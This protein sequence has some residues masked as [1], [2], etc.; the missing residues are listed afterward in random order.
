MEIVDVSP[1]RA[2][3]DITIDRYLQSVSGKALCVAMSSSGR[4]LYLGGHSGVWRSDDGGQH[5]VHPERPNPPP[6]STDV[7]GALYPPAV[8]DLLVSPTNSDVVLAATGRDSRRPATDGIYRSRDAANSWQRVHAFTNPAGSVG[9]VACLAVA[10]DDP[11]LMFSGGQ[12]ALGRSEDAGRTWTEVFPQSNRSQQVWYVVCG[13]AAGTRRRVYAVGSRVWYSVDGGQTWA[14]DPVALSA[15]SPAD[16]LGQSARCLDIDPTDPNTIYLA[17]QAG[18]LWRGRFPASGTA[19]GSW[20]R[21]PAPPA[22]YEGT[23]ASGTDFIVIHRAPDERRYLVYSD[24]RTVHLSVGDP[25][26]ASDWTRIDPSPVHLDPHGIAL[27]ATFGWEGAGT[28]SGRIAMVN[29]GGAV[30]ST[31]GAKSWDFGVGLSTL[32]LVNAAVLPREGHPPALVIQMGDNSGFFSF[33]GGRSWRTQDYVGGDND[34]SFV[35]PAQPSRL[36]VFAPRDRPRKVYLYRARPGA[37]I[38]DGSWGTHDR[39]TVPGPPPVDVSDNDKDDPLSLWNCVSGFFNQGNRPL[40]LTLDGEEPRPDGDFLTI[41]LANPGVGGDTAVAKLLRTTAM[42]KIS[43]HADWLTDADSE[44]EGT[45]VFQ[46]GSDLPDP[47]IGVVQPSGGHAHPTFYVGDPAEGAQQRVWKWRDGMDAWQQVVPGIGP[48][49]P[50]IARRFFVDP[51]RPTILYVLGR[52]HVHLSNDGGRTWRIEAELEAAL[53]QGGAFPVDLTSEAGSDQAL[54]RDMV[55]HPS[56]STWRVAIG[57]A[58]VFQTRNAR[59]WDHLLHSA[60][61]TMRP[62]NAVL[63][64]V[65]RAGSHDLY[66]ATSNRGLLRVEARPPRESFSVRALAREC[67]GLDPPLSIRSDI[68]GEDGPQVSL[69]DRLRDIR[70]NCP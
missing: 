27:T 12:F 21:L 6:R 16:G 60:A 3:T 35:D 58:G 52:D 59:T 4:R 5:W 67:L 28:A 57:P 36:I 62:N 7:P 39:K 14:Q 56:S 20:T 24:R 29:D 51:Y 32:G 30:V 54:L 38:P 10:P 55:F 61:A 50:T 45:K 49:A 40:V 53:T 46:Q 70:D 11:N 47:A 26:A 64:R 17:R 69:F 15:G 63:D 13:P 19:P 41:W 42:S 33:D 37:E 31:D 2:E 65:S 22:D 25:A 8:Y 18:E 23:T 44:A 34:C 43:G 66:V 48:N 1:V 68:F 9:T